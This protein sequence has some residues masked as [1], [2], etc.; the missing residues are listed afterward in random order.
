MD[1]QRWL[2][3]SAFATCLILAAAVAA[4]GVI[5]TARPT[6][7]A[8]VT[9][10]SVDREPD[11]VV[12]YNDDPHGSFVLLG[13]DIA[14][15]ETG[16]RDTDITWIRFESTY[17]SGRGAWSFAFAPPRGSTLGLGTYVDT[18]NVDYRAAGQAGLSVQ[19]QMYCF[20][21]TGRFTIHEIE[22]TAT[23]LSVFSATFRFKC[24]EKDRTFNPGWVY[25]EIRYNASDGFRAA[26]TSPIALDFGTHPVGA[27]A[28]QSI[29]TVSSIGTLPVSLGAG[30]IIGQDDPAFAVVSNGCEGATL[31][32][33]EVC[34]VRV[35][36]S[37]HAARQLV[38][39][40]TVQD[41]TYRGKRAVPLT[42]AGG[43]DPVWPFGWGAV[44][45]AARD[46]TWLGDNSLGV[47]DQGTPRLQLVFESPFVNG[48][49]IR[50][51]GPYLGVFATR[52]SVDGTRWSSA[53][54]LNQKKMHGT[55]SALAASGD[56]VVVAWVG[57][58]KYVDY[59]PKAPRVLYVRRNDDEGAADAWGPIVRLT[60]KSGRVGYPAI[61]ASGDDV[62]VTWTDSSSGKLMLAT[63]RDSGR[64]WSK[65]QIGSTRSRNSSGYWSAP[66]IA[67]DGDTVLVSWWANQGTTVKA[68]CSTDAGVTFEAAEVVGDATWQPAVATHNGRFGILMPYADR[69]Y[70]RLREGAGWRAS[71]RIPM[72]GT[73]KPQVAALVLRGKDGVGIVTPACTRNCQY[74]TTKRV[75]SSLVWRYSD[76]D[77]EHWSKARTLSRSGRRNPGTGRDANDTPSLV[78]PSGGRRAVVFDSWNSGTDRFGVYSVEGVAVD[79][80]SAGPSMVLAAAD[81]MPAYPLVA[82]RPPGRR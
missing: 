51:G 59:Q 31:Q 24:S 41:D 64:T 34:Q 38:A 11:N 68:R 29:V 55:R 2:R 72:V 49:W 50:D 18:T 19:G 28:G 65:R 71:E 74:Q 58:R 15:V 46:H 70:F 26:S 69:L 80:A 3:R 23:G 45:T 27:D 35:S 39:R 54:R 63:S 9:A 36:A 42:V 25:G 77:G 67:A 37:P 33:G 21:S 20:D 40:L 81:P 79:P 76:D 12:S 61:A 13:D 4:G 17:G 56:Y 48:R 73:T 52:K 5:A 32:P 82:R 16:R 66:S 75:E 30:A 22:S 8:T 62:Y 60:S 53:K 57:M 43:S 44:G 1:A 14:S 10:L 6:A 78:W 47:T 7:A